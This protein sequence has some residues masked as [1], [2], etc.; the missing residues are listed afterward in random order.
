VTESRKRLVL[1]VVL[2]WLAGILA[3]ITLH[4]LALW[5]SPP[6]L[7]VIWTTVFGG[8]YGLILLSVVRGLED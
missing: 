4:V 5:D 2:G 7:V 1:G 8:I 3:G 6:A